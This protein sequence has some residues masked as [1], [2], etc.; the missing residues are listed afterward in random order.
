MDPEHYR[1]PKR[2]A[3]EGLPLFDAPAPPPPAPIPA[4]EAVRPRLSDPDTSRRAAKTMEPRVHNL[5]AQVLRMIR[6]HQPITAIELEQFA[7]FAHLAPSTVRKRVSE[8]AQ[9]KYLGACGVR[10]V[11][12]AWGTTTKGTLYELTER[13]HARLQ[14]LAA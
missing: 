9:W 14:Q 5:H 2:P 12:T 8:L 3:A 6:T 7:D 1:P 4:R 11:R 10:E 13:G